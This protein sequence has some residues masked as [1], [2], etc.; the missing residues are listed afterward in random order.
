MRE[1]MT[2]DAE[3]RAPSFTQWLIADVRDGISDVVWASIAVGLVWIA[4]DLLRPLL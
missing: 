1:T 4:A 2:F 3:E